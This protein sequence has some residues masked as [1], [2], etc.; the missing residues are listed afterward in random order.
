[1][2]PDFL[3]SQ[4]RFL[5]GIVSWYIL[6]SCH[7]DNSIDPPN[8]SSMNR[9]L[10][11]LCQKLKEDSVHCP[12]SQDRFHSGY[13]TM[14]K[15]LKD[16]EKLNAL[17]KGMVMLDAQI[18]L[19]RRAVYHKSCRLVCNNAMVKIPELKLKRIS[20]QSIELPSPKKDAQNL[21]V[22]YVV[23]TLKARLFI[24]YYHILLTEI[25]KYG[26]PCQ[27]CYCIRCA[28][29]GRILATLAMFL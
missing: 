6:V 12:V 11:C 26:L 2:E 16:I 28:C 27:T 5:Q 14:E 7:S 19:A 8:I 18:M 20:E 1:M 17:P 22:L 24:K 10:C 9:S 21:N 15:D 23:K 25:S 13:D 29:H 4:Y 3:L